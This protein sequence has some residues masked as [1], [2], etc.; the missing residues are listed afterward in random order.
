MMASICRFS[1][2][3]TIY[4]C[5]YLPYLNKHHIKPQRTA[6]VANKLGC[7]DVVFTA[8][9]CEA[10]LACSTCHV[11]VEVRVLPAK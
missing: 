8:G 5:H 1:E 3:L 2:Q 6:C 9:A 7:L 11:V 4:M 10:S